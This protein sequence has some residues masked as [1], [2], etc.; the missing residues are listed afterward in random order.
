MSRSA[1]P[2][3]QNSQDDAAAPANCPGWHCWQPL[4]R[5]S[6][7]AV[8]TRAT[9]CDPAKPGRQA[10]EALKVGPKRLISVTS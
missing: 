7:S 4:S 2:D 3:A 9:G 6:P 5:Y 8:Q 1:L 10:A